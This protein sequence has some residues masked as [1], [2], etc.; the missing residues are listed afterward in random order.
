MENLTGFRDPYVFSSPL[1]E[2]LLSNTTTQTNATGSLFATIS[3]GIRT[4]A[5]PNGGPRLFL[6]RQTKENEFRDWT[7]LG[8][9]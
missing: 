6:Y 4:D 5:D 9:L 8:A 7:Y 2:K 3:S 1:L